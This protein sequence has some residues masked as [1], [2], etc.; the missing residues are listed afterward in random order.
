[1]AID[2]GTDYATILPGGQLILDMSPS[3]I[4]GPIVPM[5]R[6]IRAWLDGP[7]RGA[8]ERTWTPIELAAMGARLKV[9]AEQ[10]DYVLRATTLFTL[11]TSK[12]FIARGEITVGGSGTFPL[13]VT[14]IRELPGVLIALGT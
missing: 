2:Y 1:M 12:H 3:R 8:I 11:G 6:V 14:Q 5:V 9:I 13:S 10:V 7:L 4:Q